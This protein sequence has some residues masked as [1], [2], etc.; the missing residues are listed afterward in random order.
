[1]DQNNIFK[2]PNSTDSEA[3]LIKFQNLFLAEK[4]KNDNFQPA[5]KVIRLTGENAGMESFTV[6]SRLQFHLNVL[7][8][9]IISESFAIRQETR[10]AESGRSKH[11]PNG[12]DPWRCYR[13]IEQI[14]IL[15]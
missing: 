6:Q 14:K 10:T 12:P 9:S 7:Q 2:R 5:A 13:E 1:M 15:I 4:S 8:S 3:D 11:I